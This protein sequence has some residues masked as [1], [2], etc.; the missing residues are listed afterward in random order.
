M[1]SATVDDNALMHL[2][3]GDFVAVVT[4]HMKDG[5][6]HWTLG[7]VETPPYLRDVE[8][9]L[10]EKQR[11]EYYDEDDTP[12]NPES[13]EL[14]KRIAQVKQDLQKSID[15]S[16]DLTKQLRARRAAIMQRLREVD[17]YVAESKAA[18]EAARDDVESIPDCYWQEL[19]SYRMPPKMVLVIIRA[20]MLLLSEDDA[21][22][23]LQMQRVL[24]DFDFKRRITS[25]DPN[26][27]L[28]SK[29][30]NY[31]LQECVSKRSFR[32]DRAMQCSMAIGPIYY[33]VLAQLDSGEAQSQKDHVN[34]ERI[35][36]QKE[37]RGVL[38]QIAE[39]EKRIAEYQELMDDLDDQLRVCNQGNSNGSTVSR[40]HHRISANDRYAESLAACEGKEYLRPA[41]YAWKPTDRVIIVLRKNIVCNFGAVTLQG[42]EEEGY[43]MS[44]SQI[45]MLDAALMRHQQAL[46]AMG[47]DDEEREDKAL[48]E[49]MFKQSDSEAHSTL[50]SDED[51]LE[52]RQRNATEATSKLQRKFEGK[53]WQR[54]LDRKRD[55]I[56]AAFTEESAT[57]L[58]VPEYYISIDDLTVGSLLVDFSVQHDGQ[59]TDAELQGCVKACGYPKVMSL[60]EED[61]EDEE[62]GEG[63]EHQMKFG[64]DFWAGITSEHRGEIEAAFLEDTSA[65]TGAPQDEIVVH[66]IRADADEGL[67]VDYSMLSTGCNPDEVQKRVDAYAYPAVWG[68]YQRLAG[69]DGVGPIH[70]VR[71]CGER[72][73]DIMPGA[74]E[75]I[76]EAFIEDTADALG[77]APQQVIPDEIRYENGLTASY[78]V[79]HC[80]LDDDEVD[81]KAEHYHYPS[82]WALYDRLV[83]A[84]VGAAYQKSF[85]GDGWETVLRAARPEV[86]E[87]FCID[88]ARA[89]KSAPCKVDL[90]SM[91]TDQN[92]LLVSYNVGDSQQRADEVRE[93]TRKYPYPEVWALYQMIMAEE[94]KGTQNLTQ[95][96]DGE[97]WEAINERIPEQVREAFTEDVAVATRVDQVC[98][99]IHSINTRKMGMTV[100][101]GLAR[102]KGQ[103]SYAMHK[104]AKDFDYPATWSLY[105]ANKKSA[106]TRSIGKRASGILE[107]CFEGED[108]DIIVEGYPEELRDAFCS[109]A[110]RVMGV[111][112][113]NVSI[114]SAEID[115][116]IVKYQIVDP[117]CEDS[118]I[119][120][121]VEEDDFPEVMALY[122]RRMRGGDE[123]AA[124]KSPA[125]PELQNLEGMLPKMFD[126]DE[127]GFVMANHR[128]RLEEAFVR[129]TADALGVSA[130]QVIVEE[131][132]ADVYMLR[133][134]YRV[135]DCP[136]D[137]AA[138][139]AAV[140]DYPYPLVWEM[141]PDEEDLGK[142][143]RTFDGTAWE[144][145]V[146]SHENAVKE[147]FAKDVA[148]ALNTDRHY[149]I[150]KSVRANAEGLVV[151][152]NVMNEACYDGQVMDMRLKYGYPKT[153]AL[154]GMEKKG[155][156][157]TTSHQVG[158]DGDDWVY[159]VQEKMP[160]LQKAF[161]NCTAELFHIDAEHVTSTKYT[162]GSLIVD[163]EL[164][165]P[166]E[167][168]EEEIRKQLTACPYEPVWEL[169][170]YHPWDSTEVT[171]TTHEVCFKGPGWA[172]VLGSQ[173]KELEECFRQGTATALEVELADVRIDSANCTKEFLFIHTTVT[174][175]VF[176]DKELLQEQLSRYPYEEVWKLYVEDPDQGWTTTSHQVGFDGDDWEYILAVKRKSLEDAFRTCTCRSLE[177]TDEHITNIVF[178]TNEK[179]LLTTFE[180]KHPKEQSEAGVNQKLAECDYMPVWEL[181]IDHPYNPE[182]LETTSHEI[183]FEGEEWNK[184]IET[185]PKQLEEAIMLDA[186]DALDVTPNDITS[187]KTSFENGTVLIVR[188]NIQHPVLQDKEL[189]QE[190]LGRYPHERV[191]ALY[192]D[193]PLT[194][195]SKENAD[196]FCR[197]AEGASGILERCFEG[198]DWDIIVEGCSEELRDAFCSDAA[199]VMGV[200]KHNVSIISAEIGSLIV[201]YQI[202]DP[203]C[204]DSEIAQRVEEDD[205]PEVMA[206]YR[207]RMRGGD[208]G[209]AAKSPAVPEKEREM[210]TT[211]QDCGF[212]GTDWDYVWS[213]KQEAMCE[214]FAQGVA[215][216]LGIRPAD[217]QNINMEKSDDGIVLGASVTHPLVQDYQT[218]QK[219]LKDHPFEELWV[220]YE[221]RPYDPCE[222]V[223]TEHV[224]YFEGDK[225]GSVMESR[226][227]EVVGAIRKDTASA[228]KLLEDDVVSVCTKVES[229]GLVATVVVSHSPLQ[230]DELIQ[231]ELIKCEYEHLWALYCPEDEAPHGT[232]HFDGLNWASVIANDKDSVMQAFRMDTA[233]AI[234]VHP[235]DVDVDD[236]RTTDE[237]MDVDY[238]VNFANASEE[239]TEH[240]LQA[241]PYPNVWDHYRV[242]E[243]EEREMTTTLQDCGFEGTDWD[244]VWSIK[245]EAMCEAFAQGVADALGIRPADVQNINMEK[246]DDGIVLGASVTHPLV[247]DY[248]TIQKA[249]KDHPFEEL[250]VLYEMRPCVANVLKSS[251]A[252][253]GERES[254][255]LQR[256]FSGHDWDLVLKFCREEA[257]D[258]FRKG[259]A[260]SV[261]VVK[262]DVVVVDMRI[263]SLIVKYKVRG[264]NLESEEINERVNAYDFPELMALYRARVRGGD[265]DEGE[266]SV[267]RSSAMQPE[268]VIPVDVADESEPPEGYKRVAL[269]VNFEGELWVQI[270]KTHR[271]E[272]AGAFRADTAKSIGVT[273]ED[274]H[275]PECIVS[276]V[277]LLVHFSVLYAET[278]TEE[279]LRHKV[280]EYSYSDVWALY[281]DMAESL[282]AA[283]SE[284]MV[285]HFDG[286]NW[287]IVMEAY[288]T[289]VLEAFKE[290][291][292]NVLQSDVSRVFVEDI[293]LGSLVVRFRV[294]GLRISLKRATLLVDNYAYPK[295]WALYIPREEA[296]RPTS[297]CSTSENRSRHS[298]RRTEHLVSGEG[299]AP[300]DTVTYLRKALADAR[301]ERDM[302]MEQAEQAEMAQRAS[303]KK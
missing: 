243:E 4:H 270:V 238:T 34:R 117:P 60:Y 17:N 5:K 273:L 212:E 96:F 92:R 94:S 116:L 13:E 81:S 184:V 245:Q 36:R 114:I 63:P 73:A 181:Y 140:E 95:A 122:R 83:A 22:T 230:D 139:Q 49:D 228:L 303:E 55:A 183:G 240:I 261:D 104:A 178:E 10:W 215:D 244:Y 120:Q 141:Y 241:Y 58:M 271:R 278:A 167:L 267:S 12:A 123:G 269:S 187:I 144:E 19:K 213:I 91:D 87:A 84:V 86:S 126:G 235:E 290:D 292:A 129:D 264:C 57:C 194:P 203:P 298:R 145:V 53:N 43:T 239:D 258:A 283:V 208:E 162:L 8:I 197:D 202:V 61:D 263:G 284:V 237:G 115:S 266:G 168:S 137:K 218:I 179:A 89:I 37:L 224:I 177:L 299:V 7:S 69:L 101:Y 56:E 281:D 186:A 132:T 262:S 125:V 285:K 64:G 153:W 46:E 107:R 29:R 173:R 27:Q 223:K 102:E 1:T 23:W 82:T 277:S 275:I 296:N 97:G 98:V 31:I 163:F 62:I 71:F 253:A 204:E 172:T 199:R 2:S 30:R 109:D 276:A 234:G 130:E 108:W 289:R 274:I 225:W 21:R 75:A 176:Q 124:A 164:T 210:T 54:V 301:R 291:T 138:V 196:G 119:A 227:E 195:L 142:Y 272:L 280:D 160:E 136:S 47:E 74:E 189:I 28:S 182:E 255:E 121:R 44:H 256:V 219:A 9:R 206:L 38:K 174:H 15:Q 171:E 16:T 32:Y 302:Y 148:D 113:H 103:S 33:W 134:E 191:W 48:E 250:W 155:G 216:A 252:G 68:L 131:M 11:L 128:A 259:V 41:F 50:R 236:I 200:S 156:W 79:A 127:W 205:F 18:R 232:K 20:V 52:E 166:A 268:E 201:K 297:S 149:V 165:H 188:L 249:L 211:L 254:C 265:E 295:V 226:G 143:Q 85:E 147:A 158:F 26:Q 111:S 169:Y 76:K 170:G 100:E 93:S 105:E 14:M 151:R 110:A 286:V 251:L 133:V 78:A 192:E 66:D 288:P 246:S 257:S 207:R 72:W 233:T 193:A 80:T 279:E 231:E 287:G 65:A 180:V 229:T 146:A 70:H 24:R 99:T 35:A 260:D 90:R 106:P 190:Q 118:E 154:Y 214:A 88:T 222:V 209:A 67:T 294:R 221:T 42:H 220:L 282:A 39:Q 159:V 135:L 157:V 248:Q 59:R 51:I 40:P 152:Y 150:V 25:Y 77:V 161:V 217:V 198:E 300:E 185:Q 3:V 293:A 45:E 175:H 242:G 247:Q 6:L 112:K